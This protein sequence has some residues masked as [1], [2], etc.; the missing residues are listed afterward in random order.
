MGLS[1]NMRSWTWGS[2][3]GALRAGVGV[4]LLGLSLAQSVP[5]Q[6]SCSAAVAP[7]SLTQP[8]YQ[9]IA[10]DT[11]AGFIAPL[12][13]SF[14][15]TVQ[16]NP[17]PGDLIL[18]IKN[19]ISKVPSESTK[20]VLMYEIGFLVCV[21]IGISYI[22]LMPIVGLFLACCRCCGNCGGNMYQK[23]SSSIHCRRRTLYWSA[24]ITTVIILAGNVCMFKSNEDLNV[25]VDQSPEQFNKMIDNIHT[26]LTAVPQQI[27]YVV[28][29]SYSIVQKVISNLDA[30][31]PQLGTKIQQQLRGTLYPVL[32]S[33]T[34]LD[35]EA[36]NISVQLNTFNS[37]LSQ[38]QSSLNHLKM[39]ITDVKN[40]INNTLSNPNC[41]GCSNEKSVLEKLTIDTSINIPGL[42]ELQSAVNEL[43]NINL[44]SKVK[45]VEAYFNNTPE[46]VTNATKD[47][48]ESSKQQLADIKTQISQVSSKI[49]L[50][51]LTNVSSILNQAQTQISV[52]TPEVKKAEFI[53]WSVSIALCCVV[54][55]VVACNVL[56]LVLGPLGLA[57]KADPTKRSCTADCGGTLFMMGAGFSFLFSWLFMIV[58]LLLFLL[59]GNVYTLICQPLS[60]GQLLK[61]IDTP[62]LIPNL[63]IGQTLGLKTKLSISEIYTSCEANQPVWTAL[64]LSEVINLDDL[65]NVSKYTGQ[66]QQQ[67]DKTN[68]TLPT[69]TLLNPDVKSQLSSFTAM[70]TKFDTPAIM[71]TMNSISSIN[72]NTT[73]DILGN[74]SDTTTNTDIKNEL[75][76]EARDL[77]QLQANIEMII[78]PQ[79]KTL[80]SSIN[81]LR[82]IIGKIN[83]TVGEVLNNVG[84]A[85]DFLNTN[86]TQIIKTES[87]TF[88]DCQLG[89]F[90]AYANWAKSMIKQ[91]VGL[92]QPV[93]GAV[94][95]MKTIVCSQVVESLNAFWLSL[96]WCMIFF[97]PSIIFSIK[98]AKYYR[99]MKYTDVYDNHIVMTHIPRAQMKVQ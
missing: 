81:G 44:K 95:F 6:S 68:I 13:H 37:S 80:N 52:V 93:A 55:L 45:E 2:S 39:N 29:E 86:A 10:Q 56:G 69:I 91:R 57:P 33:V 92:C 72:L 53:R 51:T 9:N 94:D 14:L 98:L 70:A 67:F 4:M 99:R 77:R 63:D 47:V 17:F 3:T 66:I 27:N 7:Q 48:V 8:Q 62:G 65:L 85:Q 90:T 28:N 11:S 30:I 22:V 88:L 36:V 75:Y 49:P 16:P 32:S 35:Q 15:H 60:N 74:L 21:A 71:D 83:G 46:M 84:I 31:G 79:L 64:H 25:S 40:R 89:Y 24:F 96:G 59:G 23:Q 1:E 41:T 61:F 42:N 82:S 26:F 5:P 19:E 18:K 34:L 20:E 12:V 87:K 54:L 97:I 76:N 50:S 38:L 73:A 58:V 78:I 43:I